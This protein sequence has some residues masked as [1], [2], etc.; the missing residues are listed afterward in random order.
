MASE[1]NLIEKK[2]FYGMSLKAF[3]LMAFF[4]GYKAN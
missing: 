4:S 1:N 3:I 2:S